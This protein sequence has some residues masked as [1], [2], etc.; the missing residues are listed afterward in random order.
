MANVNRYFLSRS[1]ST[2]K[3]PKRARAAIP[4][5]IIPINVKKPPMIATNFG[6]LCHLRSKLFHSKAFSF[7][8]T[9]Y[10]SLDF[11][12]AVMTAVKT[13][14]IEFSI[15]NLK[16]N[17]PTYYDCGHQMTEKLQ[18]KV[19][20]FTQFILPFSALSENRKEQFT[21]EM[22]KAAIFCF[23]EIERA[24][25]GGLILKQP[26][27]KPAFIAE[28]CYP[29]WLISWSKFNLLFDGLSARAYNLTYTVIPDLKT[30][31]ENEERSSKTLETYM[32]FLSDNVNYFQTP[33]P[34]EEMVIKGLVTDPN[35][36]SEFALYLSEA[37]QVE[38]SSPDLAMLPPT[39]DE[40]TVSSITLELEN[41]KSEFEE[42]LDDLYKNM[43]LLNKTTR[44]FVKTISSKIK[45]IKEEFGR[46][47]KK[48]ESIITPK[49]NRINE[50][51]D[52]QIT[53]L[54]ND[55]EKRLLPVQKEKLKLEKTKEQ[56]L[57]KIE[58]C[59]IEAKTCAANKDVVG[60]R[61]WKEKAN[62]SKKELSEIEAKIKELE[63]KMK[64]IEE[65][66]SLETFK[67]RSEWEAKVKEAKKDLLELESSRDAKIQIHK[68]EIEKLEK[69]T[70]TIIEQIGKM[71]K[72]REA[73]LAEFEKLGIEQKQKKNVL[74]YM[75]FYLVCYQS[76]S[77]RRYVPFSPSI[78]NS[79][80]LLAKLKGALGRA[81]VKQ[82]LVPRFRAIT[83]FLNKF[84]A[85]I[86]RDAVFE[87]E[88]NEAS[89]KADMLKINSMREQIGNGLK[90]LKEEGWLSEKEYEAF[91]ETYAKNYA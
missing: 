78:A 35:F 62:E 25:G 45:T 36:L 71:A 46:E 3:Y 32:A 49:V 88:I 34:E 1:R 8:G 51:Y 91:A 86:E 10:K 22:E 80:S 56:T 57:N 2:F 79:I 90:R 66:R 76:Q 53:K 64:E 47:I 29:F 74:I 19:T 4:S 24:K 39:I 43:K 14:R 68:Q 81:K 52:E 28:I 16:T 44:N 37:K 60:E 33:M 87:R 6:K 13:M 27:E 5:R 42:G 38:T 58:R 65:S 72:M 9:L 17:L 7:N 82:L 89:D 85:L 75:P 59:K 73:K 23:S 40:S 21:E 26:V 83:V 12:T 70:S 55:F 11:S 50:E 61:K 18:P 20:Q 67:L 15:T 84:P 41:L 31:M 48:Q 69:L 63:G 30:F 77:K 54:T